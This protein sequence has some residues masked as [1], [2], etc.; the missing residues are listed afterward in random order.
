MTTPVR[1]A[2][3]AV[4]AVAWLAVSQ[5]AYAYLDPSTA[6]MIISAI[7]GLLATAS[8]AIKTF[9]YKIKSFFRR[10]DD[11]DPDRDEPAEH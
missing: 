7:V 10:R 9:W 8:L 3:A 1:I 4:L 2:C 5:P 6:S 11:V